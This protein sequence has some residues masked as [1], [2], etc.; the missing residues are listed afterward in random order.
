MKRA[1]ERNA[2][3]LNKVKEDKAL[4]IKNLGWLLSQTR[5]DIVECVYFCREWPSGF[6]CEFMDIKFTNNRQI[7][8]DITLDSYIDIIDDA[9]REIGRD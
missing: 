9:I 8:V 1:N 2:F 5:K 3:L 7:R 4:F 6:I